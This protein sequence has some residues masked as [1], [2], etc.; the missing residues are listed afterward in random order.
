MVPAG[1]P[2]VQHALLAL[3]DL[4]ARGEVSLE[5]VVDKTSHA[6]A[7]IFGVVDRGYLREGYFA[8]LAIVD[9]DAPYTV[10]SDNLLAKCHWS[11]FDGHTFSSSI[12]TTIVNGQF[13]F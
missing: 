7:D 13:V 9:T 11:P 8:D 3:F 6:V 4:V 12:H 5:R 1:L 10:G 2:L